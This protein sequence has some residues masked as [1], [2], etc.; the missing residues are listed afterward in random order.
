MYL[1]TYDNNILLSFLE[2]CAEKQV[3]QYH[4]EIFT[5][6]TYLGV[7]SHTEINLHHA[8]LACCT[9]SK[10]R[11]YTQVYTIPGNTYNFQMPIYVA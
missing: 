6:C 10:L 9:C 4:M 7:T 11:M 8:L 2:F 1:R 5:T 3:F